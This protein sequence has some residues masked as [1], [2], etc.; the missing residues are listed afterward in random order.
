[1]AASR[2]E[3]EGP[4]PLGQFPCGNMSE[5]LPQALQCNGH[6]DCLNG[7]DESHCGES[8][9]EKEPHILLCGSQLLCQAT[10]QTLY[11]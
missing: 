4:C 9:G 2:A 8:E 1:M 3:E 6:K 7:A 10:A 11:V 5:C